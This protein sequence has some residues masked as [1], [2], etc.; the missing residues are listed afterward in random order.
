MPLWRRTLYI[1]F[2]ARLV[3][4]V[5]FSVIFPFLPLY[6]ADLG[7][8][9]GASIELLAGLVFSAQAF[10]MMLAS[11]VWGAVAD[12]YGRKLMVERSM[13]GGAAIMLL[14]AFA[15]S[16]EQLVIL[17]AIQG[18]ITGVVS[19][20]SALV[21]AVAPRDRT[22]YA[23]GMM[24]LGTWSGVAV[25]PILG[26]IIAD[27]VGFEATF[28]VTA[29]LLFLAGILVLFGIEEEFTPAEENRK[30]NIFGGWK[31]IFSEPAVT[32][33]Y[34]LRFTSWLG[35]TMLVPIAPLFVVSLLAS[36]NDVGKITGFMVGI[37]AAAG[38]AGAVYFGRL[39]DRIGHRP[40][41]IWGATAAALFYFPQSL[42]T[43]IW[44]L[45]LLQGLAGAAAGSIL[46]SLSAMLVQ[47]T[48]PGDEGAVYGI[49]NSV[50]AASRTLA[51][52]IGGAVAS[53]LGL[54]ITF[55]L[56]ALLFL[57]AVWVAIRFLPDQ[58]AVQPKPAEVPS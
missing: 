20:T 43:N 53:I 42:V 19:A 44:Q 3:T 12:R 45:I 41:F 5:G 58:P 15:T 54:R 13:L 31:R 30:I 47:Y 25:G 16:A 48:Q 34:S 50:V 46:P 27:E 57:V 23:M 17:R 21:A 29:S 4:A 51:P 55:V 10:T 1:M 35:R 28:I 52:L 11:P 26:G 40:I 24:Q 36:D 49:E 2:F 7:S 18:T 37:S 32:T 8:S 14:M 33:T 6:V 9:S 38:T 56:A 22:G 39:G